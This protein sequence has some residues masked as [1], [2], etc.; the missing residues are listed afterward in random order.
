MIK[1]SLALILLVVLIQGNVIASSSDESGDFPIS[2]RDSTQAKVSFG[3]NNFNEHYLITWSDATINSRTDVDIYGRILDGTGKAISKDIGISTGVS[4]QAISAVA[5]DS[6]NKRYLVIW[7][8]W[9]KATA[10]DSDIWGQFINADG[11]L[12]GDNFVISEQRAVSQKDAAVAYDPARQQFLVVWKD[13]RGNSLEKLHGRYIHSN[14][15]PKGKEFIIAKGAG[16]QDRPS[17]YYDPRRKRFLAIWRDIVDDHLEKTTLLRGKGIFARFIDPAK[18]HLPT[19]GKLIDLEDDACLPTSL[20]AAAYSP[21]S[22][23]FMVT[24]TT[25]RDY[26]KL[27]LDA[28]GAIIRADD[29]E[30]VT[31]PFAIARTTDYQEFPAVTYDK[32]NNRF[33]AVWYDLRR[34]HSAKNADIYGRFVEPTGKMSKE[35]LISDLNMHGEKRYPVP[36]YSEKQDA[37][38]IFWQDNRNAQRIYGKL[39]KN[40]YAAAE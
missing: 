11:S 10:V 33:L 29:A 21:D 26:Q 18:P 15:K 37:F 22:D 34:D 17:L 9:R 1:K 6:S 20:Y 16:K 30:L 5:F 39:K 13:S 31:K 32:H 12:Y 23:V 8:D 38:L 24:W 4:G 14:G 3:F 25:A 40:K 28:F 7:A 27:G 36:A 19:P 2:E 35:F